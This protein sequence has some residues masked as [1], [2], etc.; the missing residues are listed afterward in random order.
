MVNGKSKAKRGKNQRGKELFVQRFYNMVAGR[1]Y[2]S[3][4][5]SIEQSIR[6]QMIDYGLFFSTS[7]T[8]NIYQA[9]Q[10]SLAAF[11][12]YGAY[13]ALFD[14]YM[15]EQ[16][17]LWLEPTTQNAADY[18]DVATCIDLDDATVP[19]SFGQVA[20]HQGAM[21]GLGA[22]GRY[23]KWRPHVAVAT[24]SGAFTSYGNVP[25]MWIDSGSPS[26]QHYGWKCAMLSPGVVINYQVTVRAVVCF[27]APGIS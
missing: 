11:S 18:S 9:F 23:V 24:Y 20:D 8:A 13:V 17:E 10:F 7:N 16:L 12:G 22:S 26:V 1:P 5:I 27:R 25:S 19:T 2:P 3:N 21:V 15:I 6:V 14:Q 4:R